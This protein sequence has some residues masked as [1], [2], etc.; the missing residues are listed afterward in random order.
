LNA[1]INKE[2]RNYSES[3]FF[4]L[5]M[6]QFVFSLLAV[7]VAVGLYFLLCPYFGLET[8]S[9]MVILAAA[10]FAVM[11]FVSYHGMSAEQFLIT[12]IR[13]ELIEP[14]QLSVQVNNLYYEAMKKWIAAKE[15]GGKRKRVKNT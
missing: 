14:R 12:W 15:K 9:W 7:L 8:L 6:R 4:G 11:G 5:S 10:P 2:I 1:K 3:I 13:S